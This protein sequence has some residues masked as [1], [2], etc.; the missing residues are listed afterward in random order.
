[1][2][3]LTDAEPYLKVV[4]LWYYL[5]RKLKIIELPLATIVMPVYY[6]SQIEI[7][8]REEDKR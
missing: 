8:Q 2:P 5:V 1:M 3:C 7:L 6:F 4:G